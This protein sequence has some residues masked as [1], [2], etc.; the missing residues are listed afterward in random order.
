M[1]V[2]CIILNYN[3]AKTTESLVN[4]IRNYKC[5]D[6]IVVVDNHSTDDSPAILKELEDDKVHFLSSPK[7]GGYG[8]GNNLGIRYAYHTLHAT[9]VLIAN[10]DV[11]VSED[12]IDAMKEAFS[13]EDRLAV[14]AA[15]TTD[16]TGVVALSSWRLNGVFLDLLDTGLITRRLFGRWLNDRPEIKKN[17]YGSGNETKEYA[18]VDAVLGSLFLADAKALMECGLYDER[19]FLYYEEKILGHKL[20]EKG[21]KTALLLDQSYVHLHSVSIKKSVES[22]LKRQALLHE[23]KLYY[24]KTYLKI[25]RLEEVLVKLFLGILMVEIWFLTKIVGLS[26]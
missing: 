7:N 25:N 6:S 17:I 19:V 15:V 12:C 11:K 8:Y 10:P 16:G 21:Y 13:K 24:Y 20:K 5:L 3:D 14:A 2:S 9:H 22:I 23:S 26:W 1:N 18:Y 4:A